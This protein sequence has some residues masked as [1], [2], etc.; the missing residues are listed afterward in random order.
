M[1]SVWIALRDGRN[2]G[3]STALRSGRDDKFYVPGELMK[4][5]RIGIIMNGVTGRM[6]LNQHLVRSILAIR[7]QGGVTLADGSR[8]MPDPI[9]VG[10]NAAK[11][12]QIAKE[13]NVA[14]WTTDLAAA[15]ADPHDALYFDAQITTMRVAS[16]EAA[17]AA[18]KHVYCEKP[19]AV[20]S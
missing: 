9:L 12:E 2:A 17:I 16:V 4:E 10:R 18:G 8:L 13:H 3:P 6:G 14:R 20:D 11:L 7:A 1:A 19:L 15:L 5:Q